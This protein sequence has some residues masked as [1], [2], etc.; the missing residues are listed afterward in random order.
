MRQQCKTIIIHSPH[1]GR[2]DQFEETLHQLAQA[3]LTPSEILSIAELDNR[4]IQGPS[5]KA[6]GIEL[7]IAAGGD[8]LVGGVITHIVESGIPLGILP[9]GTSNDTS[10]ALSIPQDIQQAIDV[11]RTGEIDEIDIGLV[12]PAEQAPHRSQQASNQ[13][14]YHKVPL[15]HHG[16]FAHIS[17]V[18]V[19]VQFAHVATDAEIRQRYGGL[20]YPV[21]AFEVFRNRKAVNLEL[22]AYNVM[23]KESRIP[24]LASNND[25]VILHYR[26]LLGAVVNAPIFAGAFQLALPGGS[27]HDGFLDIIVVEE[28]DLD[29]LA[30]NLARFFRRQE[31]EEQVPAEQPYKHDERLP[32]VELSTIPGIHHLRAKGAILRTDIDPQDITLDGEVRGQTPALLRIADQRLRVIVPVAEKYNVL[33]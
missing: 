13:T 18:G 29:N 9:L 24:L 8:G 1:S 2:A 26:T 15:Q 10:R 4:P 19:N 7:V 23:P 33:F 12:Q 30:S 25:P 20:T 5:W 17:T 3:G 32:L 6:K 27:V 22:H 14:T 16:Y 11:L 21:A 28:F 31:R